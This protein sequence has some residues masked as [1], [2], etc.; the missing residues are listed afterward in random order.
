MDV[1]GPEL[2]KAVENPANEAV[3]GW[4]MVR[5]CD[6]ELKYFKPVI[7]IDEYHVITVKSG[8]AGVDLMIL[9]EIENIKRQL[10]ENNGTIHK[11]EVISAGR[12]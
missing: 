5:G 2:T 9:K 7:K 6:E 10:L 3:F 8:N 4:L 1:L 12:K 11:S